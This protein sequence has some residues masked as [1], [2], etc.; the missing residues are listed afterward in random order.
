MQL[1]WF[2]IRVCFPVTDV[3]ILVLLIGLLTLWRR[4]ALKGTCEDAF[5]H[6]RPFLAGMVSE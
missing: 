6:R 1:S 4:R 2:T 5:V 3:G